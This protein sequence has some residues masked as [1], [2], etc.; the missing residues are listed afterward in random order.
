MGWQRIGKHG[1]HG[2]LVD[3]KEM[4]ESSTSIISVEIFSHHLED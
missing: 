3:W 1:V 2:W 4:L